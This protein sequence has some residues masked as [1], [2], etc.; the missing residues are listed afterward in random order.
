MVLCA[1]Q[2]LGRR[3]IARLRFSVS[4]AACHPAWCTAIGY[5]IAAVS[6]GGESSHV[7]DRGDAGGAGGQGGGASGHAQGG[8]AQG[9]DGQAGGDNGGSESG[10]AGTGGT[11]PSGGTDG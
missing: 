6:C 4:P 9:G 10:G 5:L 8:D 2:H 3:V 7:I 1:V 11:G